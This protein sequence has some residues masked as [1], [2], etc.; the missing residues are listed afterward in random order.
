MRNADPP[1]LHPAG[2]ADGALEVAVDLHH[3]QPAFH[4]LALWLHR[5]GHA[6]AWRD[7]ALAVR[8]DQGDPLGSIERGVVRPLGI[9]THA[10]HLVGTSADGRIWLQQ[11]A[12]DKAT[13]PGK[14]DTLMGGMIAAGESLEIATA[15]ET[16]EEAGIA[17]RELGGFAALRDHGIV[18]F[19]RPVPDSGTDGY[20]VERIH[21][22]SS[23]LPPPLQP[24]NQDGEVAHFELVSRQT[25][26]EWV[27]AD[28][29]TLEASLVLACCLGW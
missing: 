24:N 10:V 11:R 17:L 9:A 22:L 2:D 1:L 8:D 27:E 28:L 21:V 4:A 15:R 25:L 26:V 5:H 29:L 14:W 23:V 3:A 13:D 20:L 7:E 16:W 12:H 19:R 18:R 6:G